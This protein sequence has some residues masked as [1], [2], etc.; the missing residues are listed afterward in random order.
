MYC[1]LSKT[2]R[3]P[4]YAPIFYRLAQ[5]CKNECSRAK[6]EEYYNKAIYHDPTLSEAYYE[7]AVISEESGNDSEAKKFYKKV[8]QLDP[9][10]SPAYFKLGVDYFHK[11][12]FEYAERFLKQ[13]AKV[14]YSY[15]D[16]YYL[17]W[18][19]ML[20]QDYDMAYW[21][22]RKCVNVNSKYLFKT[23]LGIG[24][25]FHLS[26]KQDLAEEQVNTLRDLSRDNIADQL[27]RFIRTGQYPDIFPGLI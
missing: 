15:E 2:E 4:H 21:H 10:N 5:E 20:K 12:E 11:G 8:T 26:G 3:N 18:I 23:H 6:L 9:T 19:C 25:V 27:L 22:F 17:G 14:S 7:L 24:M 13:A 1:Y 16:A